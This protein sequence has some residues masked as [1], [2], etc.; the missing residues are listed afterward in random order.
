M[1]DS[2][3]NNIDSLFR[4]L[5][6]YH[7]MLHLSMSAIQ[8]LFHDSV[9]QIRNQKMFRTANG[10]IG[11]APW[12]AEPGDVIWMFMGLRIPLIIR[13]FSDGSRLIGQA[14]IEGV[15]YGEP[16]QH[17]RKTLSIVTLR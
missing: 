7:K 12:P 14:Y 15:M 4:R 10:R 9:G 17:P 16:W 3:A 11:M 13:P 8:R 1:H 6:E 5:A 2:E